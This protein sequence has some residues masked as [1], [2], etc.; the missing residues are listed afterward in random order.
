[1]KI[2][3]LPVAYLPWQTG[4]REVYC[5][6][7]C[8]ALTIHGIESVVAIH[9]DPSG[10]E[11]LG[12]HEHEG[13]PVA[14]LPPLPDFGDRKSTYTR[15][16]RE[17]PGFEALLAEVKPDLVHFHDQSGSASLSHMKMVKSLGLP[18]VL[19]YHSPGQTCLQTALLRD[20][21][22]L[23]DGELILSRC[24]ACR[25]ISTGL[26][27]VASRILALAELPGVNPWS[28]SRVARVLSAR[29]MSRL[30][31]DSLN[32][33]IRLSD[34]IIVLADW[35]REIWLRNHCPP[36][37][38]RLVR[39]GGPT[40]RGW[41]TAPRYPQRDSLRIGCIGRC[42]TI[43]GFHVLVD[44]IKSLPDLPVE[45]HF[46]GPYWDRAYG[47][48]VKQKMG[49]DRRFLP[50]RLVPNAELLPVLADLDIVVIPSIWPETGPLV[51]FEA[52][53]AGVPVVASRIGGPAELIR[54]G[55]DGRLFPPGDAMA[56]AK[57]I[58]ELTRNPASL[59]N[60][61]EGMQQEG[62]RFRRTFGEVA[63]EMASIY[64]E[65]IKRPREV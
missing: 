44:A 17:L 3:H 14:V 49:S 58:S 19:T 7:L 10:R 42:E 53:A 54:D 40:A 13:I 20:G 51:L 60:L 37:K 43:K 22:I 21:H 11:P 63:K 12:W 59:E 64:S 9:Q 34:A 41:T 50:P 4:G 62:G 29:T 35:S 55:V 26:S 45:V 15:E 32:A 46:L 27:P 48:E 52:Y 25:L 38:L 47:E 1:M 61:R 18:A 6:S 5:H 65:S 31:R 16:Y 23:C 39:T 8:R 57:I 24:T 33:F 36:E 30:F 2:L 56:L 28:K